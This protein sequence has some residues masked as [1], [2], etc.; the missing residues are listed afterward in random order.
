MLIKMQKVKFKLLLQTREP[1]EL[2]RLSLSLKFRSVLGTPVVQPRVDFLVKLEGL[3]LVLF[4]LGILN[5]G[6]LNIEHVLDI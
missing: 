4:V 1:I 5:V 6:P 2:Q 3:R